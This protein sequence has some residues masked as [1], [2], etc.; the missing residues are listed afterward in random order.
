M[1]TVIVG[2]RDIGMTSP[3]VGQERGDPVL[4]AEKR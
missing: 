3:V 4:L 2:Q 1:L